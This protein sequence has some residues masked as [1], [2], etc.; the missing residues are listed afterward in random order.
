MSAWDVLY[1]TQPESE[2][3]G[4][5]VITIPLSVVSAGSVSILL[6]LFHLER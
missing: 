4:R 3:Q 2:L 5:N 1:V 6:P